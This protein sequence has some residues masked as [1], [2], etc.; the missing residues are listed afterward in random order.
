M[1]TL[2]AT[3]VAATALALAAAAAP[4][5]AIMVGALPDTPA[6]HVDANQGG[7]PYSGAVSV[8]VNGVPFS[9]VVVAPQY[10][11]TA[12]HVVGA[13]LPATLAVQVNVD[14][15]PQVHAVTAVQR[16]ASASFPYDDLA[17]LTL[18]RPVD[19]AVVV[20]AILRSTV[21]AGTALT[22]VG[23]G[24]S[25]AGDVGPTAPASPNVKRWGRNAAP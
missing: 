6:A 1:P 2:R 12:A 4:S 11:L 7:T 17:L 13:N 10:V 25:G 15:A 16:F 9:G 8:R 3:V 18:E 20:P 5:Q 23:Y 21:P 24:A 22:L 19:P 14:G